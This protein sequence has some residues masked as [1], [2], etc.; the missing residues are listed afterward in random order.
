[1]LE[2]INLI[3]PESLLNPVPGPTPADS[4]AVVGG[5]VETSQRIVDVLIGALQLAASSQGTMNNLLFGND[6]FG[7][8]ET[9][10]GGAGATSQS[11][12]ADA[13]HT[14]MTTTRIP[15]PEILEQRYPVRLD[16]FSIRQQSGGTGKYRGGNGVVRKITFLEPV[17]VS[18]LTQRRSKNKPA[19]LAKGKAGKAGVNKILFSDGREEILKNRQ[20]LF[21]DTGDQLTIETPGGGGWGN[22]DD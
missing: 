8:Y 19:G 11:A 16:Q 7:Y 6:S 17:T 22:S 3:L 21:V 18:L 2:P 13:V 14:H 20:E 10:C 15:A 5:N 9:I 12:G 1:M 4:P